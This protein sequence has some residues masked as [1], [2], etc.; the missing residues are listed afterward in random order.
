M[1]LGCD[2]RAGLF[3]EGL[4]QVVTFTRHSGSNGTLLL[5]RVTHP[6]SPTL[7]CDPPMDQRDIA[8][9]QRAMPVV[10]PGSEIKTLASTLTNAP[11]RLA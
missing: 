9:Q 5:S 1:E 6:P 3:L 7:C 10:M 4:D 2:V 8:F 11:P